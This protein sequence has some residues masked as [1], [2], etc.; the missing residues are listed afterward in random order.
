MKRVLL[1]MCLAALVVGPLSGAAKPKTPEELM[2]ASINRPASTATLT[3]ALADLESRAGVKIRVDWPSL[4]EAG[5]KEDAKLAL[6]GGEATLMQW[7]D[8]TLASAAPKGQPLAWYLAD[9][10]IMVTTQQR[11]L[12]RKGVPLPLGARP[13]DA[14][15]DP[16]PAANAKG[17]I[18]SLPKTVKFDKTPLADVV[19]YFRTLSGVNFHINY[20]ALKD[21][22]I[23]AETPVTLEVS[24]VSLAKVMDLVMD[25]LSQNKSKFDSV[26]WIVN[27]GVV[28]IS[29][30]N[31]LNT[32]LST[33]VYDVQDMLHAMP[34]PKAPKID[35]NSMTTGKDNNSSS[36]GTNTTSIFGE[37]KNTEAGTANSRAALQDTIVAMVKESIGDDMWSP[38]G[39]GAI[40]IW[41]GKLV[42][43]QTP[44][45]FKLLERSAIGK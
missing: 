37:Q 2:N 22:N 33:R 27:D 24:N 32:T 30:G 43:S 28:S 29:T 15:T 10:V 20:A 6:S 14:K 7:L 25:N 36:T 17:P 23:T 21:V 4:L 12:A 5:V 26:Y 8:S 13:V 44:L 18:P 11:V 40:R 35:L 9:D 34:D 42:I 1:L 16:K 19:E 3:Q 31:A 38:D 41:N 45:G 39:K